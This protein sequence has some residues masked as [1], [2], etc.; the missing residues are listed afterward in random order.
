MLPA[1]RTLRSFSHRN[2]RWIPRTRY[3]F[4]YVDL[5]FRELFHETALSCCAMVCMYVLLPTIILPQLHAPPAGERTTTTRKPHQIFIY[6][7]TADDD[8]V[9]VSSISVNLGD[10]SYIFVGKS[11]AVRTTWYL[12]RKRYGKLFCT[13]GMKY[14]ECK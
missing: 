8:A 6:R 9:S 5:N 4:F 14:Q 13:R 1:F 12:I 11:E 7:S 3:S 2:R 10:L